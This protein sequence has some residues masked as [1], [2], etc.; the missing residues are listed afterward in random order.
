MKV[1]PGYQAEP[2]ATYH[3]IVHE[4]SVSFVAVLVDFARKGAI[5]DTTRMV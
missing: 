4:S 3:G 2:G 1:F 5:I